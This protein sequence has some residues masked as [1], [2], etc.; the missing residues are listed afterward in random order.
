MP[1]IQKRAKRDFSVYDSMSDEDLEMLLRDDF[2]KPEGEESD[3]DLLL[4]VTEVLAKRRNETNKGKSPAQAWES[5]KQNYRTENDYSYFPET[6][7]AKK[8]RTDMGHWRKGFAAAAAAV[9]AIII[10][11]SVTAS[12]VK[13]PREKTVV[14]WTDHAFYFAS[15][16]RSVAFFEP[17]PSDLENKTGLQKLILEKG[18]L[19]ALA[20]SW[21]PEGYEEMEV[22]TYPM[23]QRRVF[24]AQYQNNDKYIHVRIATY[25]D[26]A[27]THIT[28][29][30]QSYEI[31]HSNGIDYYIFRTYEYY[32]AAWV[33]G[34]YEC[35]LT[36]LPSMEEM[37]KMID[38]IG[39]G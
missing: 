17:N 14:Q 16:D 30:E 18:V 38:S 5:F 27:P 35:A 11:T 21:F 19:L 28:Q 34:G 24:L 1:N 26:F 25:L 33:N 29:S 39:K 20:P 12:A 8:K 3:T 22:V 15:I 6:V 23:P 9:L 4:Y 7:P 13:A 10:S 32:S 37:K 36:G 2:S 31:Y